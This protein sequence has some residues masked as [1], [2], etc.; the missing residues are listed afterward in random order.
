MPRNIELKARIADWDA[1]LRI[2]RS[3]ATA[4][5]GELHQTD[6]YFRAPF[7]RLK[8]RQFDQPPAELIAY[9]RPDRPDAKP[10]DYRIVTIDDAE[11][12]LAALDA[13]LGVWARVEKRRRAFLHDN[14]RIHRDDVATLGHFLE[15]EAVIDDRHDES[16]CRDTLVRLCQAFGLCASDLL[17]RSY[18]D[19]I[20]EGG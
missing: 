18:S 2:A 11:S 12:L 20:A 17:D 9:S 10:S 3:L 13:A 8:L 7:G 4:D 15:F 5:L 6:T 1:A 14:V 19:M 16:R